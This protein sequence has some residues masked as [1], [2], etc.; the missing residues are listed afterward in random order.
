MRLL[1][2]ACWFEFCGDPRAAGSCGRERDTTAAV[3]AVC[4]YTAASVY[5][6]RWRLRHATASFAPFYT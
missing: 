6:V 3:S 1:L 5:R 4:V 2:L